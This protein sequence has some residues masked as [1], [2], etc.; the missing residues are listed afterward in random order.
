M[1]VTNISRAIRITLKKTTRKTAH[2]TQINVSKL[3][4]KI[5][6]LVETKDFENTKRIFEFAAGAG[7]V[8]VTCHYFFFGIPAVLTK[9]DLKEGQEKMEQLLTNGIQ[10]IKENQQ[11][12]FHEIKDVKEN[13]QQ[14]NNEI[15]ELK[16]TLKKDGFITQDMEIEIT[17]K[18]I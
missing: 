15:K 18:K 11:Q 1:T 10:T 7:S 6:K 2:K 17:E 4:E 14:V 3:Q 8:V 5:N 13:Q 16:E 12:I 9:D